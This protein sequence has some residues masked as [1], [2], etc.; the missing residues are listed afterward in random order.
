MTH[1]GMHSCFSQHSKHNACTDHTSLVCQQCLLGVCDVP[2]QS[3][4]VLVAGNYLSQRC[5]SGK[6]LEAIRLTTLLLRDLL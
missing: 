4:G 1:L 6:C 3:P 2:E 5:Q